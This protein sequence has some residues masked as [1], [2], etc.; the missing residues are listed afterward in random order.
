M[1]F[2][3]TF[4]FLAPQFVGSVES[5]D[6]VYF[7]FRETAV[8]YINCGK[9]SAVILAATART[10]SAA[11]TI[12]TT[13][14]TTIIPSTTRTILQLYTFARWCTLEWPVCASAIW[15]APPVRPVRPGPPPGHPTTGLPS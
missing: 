12:R 7:F 5:E 2:I 3:M 6:H 8:E 4:K 14:T 11:T 13:A 9:V 1:C 10:T 15:A